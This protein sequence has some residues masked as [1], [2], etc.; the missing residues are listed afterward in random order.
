MYIASLMSCI[1]ALMHG[2]FMLVA[3]HIFFH[4]KIFKTC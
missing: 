1:F 4:A 3:S 2:A